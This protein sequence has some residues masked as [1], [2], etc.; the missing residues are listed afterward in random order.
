MHLI[1]CQERHLKVP[2]DDPVCLEVIVV[3]AKRVDQ[4]F[5]NLQPAAV[6]E[7]L[8]EG[9]DWDVKVK[10][11]TLVTTGG[12]K[13]LST[14]QT[15]EK[16]GVDSEGDDLRVNQRD[17]DPVVAKKS[18]TPGPELIHFIENVLQVDAVLDASFLPSFRRQVGEPDDRD[19]VLQVR[20]TNVLKHLPLLRGHETCLDHVIHGREAFAD[21]GADGAEDEER[22][23]VNVTYQCPA[24]Q[25]AIFIFTL[26]TTGDVKHESVRPGQVNELIP[27]SIHHQ[28]HIKAQD[29]GDGDLLGVFVTVHGKFLKQSPLILGQDDPVYDAEN[30]VEQSKQDELSVQQLV[31]APPPA[32]QQLVETEEGRVGDFTGI[33]DGH[34]ETEEQ[35]ETWIQP[36][37]SR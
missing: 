23:Q 20:R 35:T 15:G 3:F 4:L 32:Q 30:S 36:G 8:Q 7:E 19:P 33:S 26:N 28:S 27:P 14:N 22:R 17:A 6:E 12:V 16:K 13:K 34:P 18:R 31:D 37:Y 29:E 21:S 25:A 24:Q 1:H 10:V 11:M 9:E 2:V 5:C